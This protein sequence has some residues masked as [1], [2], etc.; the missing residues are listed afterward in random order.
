MH[1]DFLDGKQR[2]FNVSV[3][4]SLQ[5]NMFATTKEA[6]VATEAGEYEKL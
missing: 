1:P 6:G 2:F 4:N 3:E 5:P